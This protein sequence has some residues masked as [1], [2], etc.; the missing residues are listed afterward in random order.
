MSTITTCGKCHADI[1]E[2]SK[3]HHTWSNERGGTFIT[4]Q[5]EAD[6]ESGATV[7][8][9]GAKPMTNLFC[10]MLERMGIDAES[11]GDST[12]KLEDV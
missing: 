1:V 2:I 9:P 3:D 10:S 4:T 7:P 6:L 11:V 5:A 8:L 12:G